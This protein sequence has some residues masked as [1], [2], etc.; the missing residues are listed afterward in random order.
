VPALSCLQQSFCTNKPKACHGPQRGS[1]RGTLRAF[2]DGK[3]TLPRSQI[4][5]LGRAKSGLL[6]PITCPLPALSHPQVRSAAKWRPSKSRTEFPARCPAIRPQV[7]RATRSGCAPNQMALHAPKWTAT[8]PV[9]CNGAR[10][11]ESG[12]CTLHYSRYD[13]RPSQPARP[14]VC[15]GLATSVGKCGCIAG[16]IGRFSSANNMSAYMVDSGV[17]PETGGGSCRVGKEPG[18]LRPSP[19]CISKRESA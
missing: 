5:R 13:P 11:V 16:S 14:S 12:Q 1:A 10:R 17:A 15:H 9:G 6:N 19:T 4:R 7:G 2:A 8:E 18:A 3:W